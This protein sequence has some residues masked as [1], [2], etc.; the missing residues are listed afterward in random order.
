MRE[1]GSVSRGAAAPNIHSFHSLPGP[2]DP[3]QKKP[4]PAFPAIS[5]PGTTLVATWAASCCSRCSASPPPPSS[6]TPSSKSS[7][8]RA[9]EH[10]SP[11]AT[12]PTPPP[13]S[14]ASSTG[15]GLCLTKWLDQGCQSWL[16]GRCRQMSQGGAAEGVTV[17]S[18]LPVLRKLTLPISCLFATR[19][20]VSRSRSPRAIIDDKT[21]D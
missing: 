4:R 9:P 19:V 2:R 5:G 10:H 17:R 20:C 3:S 12:S 16:L 14:F 1:S 21:T 8:M 13:S 6:T 11:L 7:S 15:I 18:L